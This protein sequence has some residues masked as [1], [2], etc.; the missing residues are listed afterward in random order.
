[1][2]DRTLYRPREIIQFCTLTLE[3][4]RDS[5]IPVPLRGTAVRE[6]EYSYSRERARDPVF[7]GV[8]LHIFAA[9][10]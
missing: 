9:S 3:C 4:A 5:Q 8:S 2:I 7:S 6:A 1:M 10:F